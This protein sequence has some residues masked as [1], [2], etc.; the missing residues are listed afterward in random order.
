MTDA[1]LSDSRVKL[2]VQV[3]PVNSSG[4]QP[5]PGLGS[6]GHTSGDGGRGAACERGG[7]VNSEVI[8]ARLL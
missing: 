7:R 3:S 2:R 1:S 8:E 6:Q 4:G 5:R